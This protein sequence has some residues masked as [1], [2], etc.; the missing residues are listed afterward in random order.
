M[1]FGDLSNLYVIGRYLD[2]SFLTESFK[3]TDIFND[4]I[5]DQTFTRELTSGA[6]D[7]SAFTDVSETFTVT[8]LT[9]K[10][11]LLVLIRFLSANQLYKP[12]QILMI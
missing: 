10:L 3:N 6:L 5:A 2:D 7:L 4:Y 12:L 11:I 1:A 8:N 9:F